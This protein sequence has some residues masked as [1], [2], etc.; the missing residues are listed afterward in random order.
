MA[1]WGDVDN[2]DNDEGKET[3]FFIFPVSMS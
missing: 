1:D 2:T 3:H